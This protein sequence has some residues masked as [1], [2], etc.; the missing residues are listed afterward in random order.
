VGAELVHADGQ[1]NR[2]D[3]ANSRI[4]QFANARVKRKRQLENC[5]G[6]L[7]HQT[8]RFKHYAKYTG[9]FEEHS[10]SAEIYDFVVLHKILDAFTVAK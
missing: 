3:E 5:E 2:H 9:F 6:T 7:L 1:T 4:S 10:T 8:T